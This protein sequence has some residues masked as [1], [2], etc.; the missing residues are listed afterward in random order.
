MPKRHVRVLPVHL[1]FSS[2]FRRSSFSFTMIDSLT[3]LILCYR[4]MYWWTVCKS[5]CNIYDYNSTSFERN[6]CFMTKLFEFYACLQNVILEFWDLVRLWIRG[7]SSYTNPALS[8]TALTWLHVVQYLRDL[9]CHRA[10][11][12]VT[13]LII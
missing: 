3:P 2:P 6:F 9:Y 1:L 4:S 10:I 5:G 13:P 7:E 12:S 11:T 8:A